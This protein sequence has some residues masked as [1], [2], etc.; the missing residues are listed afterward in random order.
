VDILSLIGRESELFCEDI[1]F[2]GSKLQDLVAESRFLVIGGSGSIGQAVTREIF[3]RDPR[4]LHVVDISENNMVELVRDLR[5]TEGY[6]SGDFKTFSVDCGSVEFE[7][8]MASEDPYDY[9]FNLSALKHVRSEKDPY[10]LM[11]M[12]MV[13]VFNTIKTSDWAKH[14]E[15]KNISVYQLIKR[16]TL[17]I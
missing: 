8:L 14:K 5:S 3:K 10:T 7:A 4:A 2:N 16:Q 17:S 11:R 9:V 12:I 1:A 13:N 6:G 15:L